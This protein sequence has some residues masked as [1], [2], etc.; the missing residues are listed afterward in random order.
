MWLLLLLQLVPDSRSP[1]VRAAEEAIVQATADY[2]QLQRLQKQNQHVDPENARSVVNRLAEL[3]YEA[4]L[5][6]RAHA[7]TD[8]V[9][10]MHHL[11]MVNQHLQLFV[12]RS[13]Y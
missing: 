7:A 8:R 2:E 9:K 5:A 11:S 3:H 6:W 13:N 4:A 1:R 10:T 12:L